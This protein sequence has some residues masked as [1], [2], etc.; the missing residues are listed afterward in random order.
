MAADPS[1]PAAFAA[2]ILSFLSPCVLPL[3]SSW[4]FYLG[5]A[6]GGGRSELRRSR[7]ILSTLCFILGFS[8]VFIVL[9]LLFSGFFML[10]GKLNFV[11]NLIAGGLIVLLGLNILFNFIPFLNYEK[12]LHLAQGPRNFWGSFTVGLAFGAGWTP[13][14]GPILGSILLMAGQSGELLFSA[15]CLTAYSAGLGLPFLAAA[16]FWGFL[17]KRLSRLRALAPVIQKT[18]GL[19][20]IAIGVFMMLGRFKTL[21]GLLIRAGYSL[22]ALS[23]NGGWPARIVPALIFFLI[24]LIPALY[25]LIRKRPLRGA[26]LLVFS[27]LFLALALLQAAGFF[28]SLAVLSRWLLYAGL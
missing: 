18:S 21:N 24:A 9:S 11:I 2:G 7:L 23:Q 5:G 26:G 25:R 16:F 20:L 8:A 6:E 15:A 3:V 27:G 14:I 13:C 12:R 19:F 17:F 28:N 22:E 4:L 10:L 1:I